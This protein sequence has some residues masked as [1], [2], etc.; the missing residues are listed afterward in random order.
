MKGLFI[1]LEG[2]EGCGKSTQAKRLYGWL[3]EQD[4]DC[5]LTKEPGATNIEIREILLDN[6]N[7]TMSK[8]CELFLYLADRAEHV[9]KMIKPALE[10]DKIVISD[11]FSD[12]TIAYQAGGRNIPKEI[13]RDMNN[14]ASCGIIP[15]ITIVI[16]LGT[17][18]GLARV[19][20]KDRIEIESGDFHK[21]VRAE[22]LSIARENPDRVK[23]V[24]GTKSIEEIEEKVRKVVKPFLKKTRQLTGK[25]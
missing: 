20:K 15:D 18:M 5:I 22:Y 23:I 12:S 25:L 16:D 17:E 7:I 13:V 4:Y 1:T 19:E 14:V 3:K 10:E 24:D 8:I 6:G 21:R 2:I 9:E 11:R